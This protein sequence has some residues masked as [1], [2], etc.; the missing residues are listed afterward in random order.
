[1][2]AVGPLERE[3]V[4]ENVAAFVEFDVFFAVAPRRVVGHRDAA[5]VTVDGEAVLL[6]PEGYRAPDYVIDRDVL[7]A[8]LESVAVAVGGRAAGRE[9]PVAV[10]DAILDGHGADR[11]RVALGEKIPAVVNIVVRDA[12]SEDI[13]R[14]RRQ[15][16][17][18][19]V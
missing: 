10:G 12:A 13:S 5:V 7:A 3:I 18:E 16:A 4:G 8:E 14:P 19:A 17:R 6:I 15:L 2:V 1:M 9:R 11:P